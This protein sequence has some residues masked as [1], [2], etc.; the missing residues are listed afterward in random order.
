MYKGRGFYDGSWDLLQ[1]QFSSSDGLLLLRGAK[2][3]SKLR[4]PRNELGL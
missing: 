2:L 4:F 3:K 1:E